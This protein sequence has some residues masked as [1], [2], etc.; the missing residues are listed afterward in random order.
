MKAGRAFLCPSFLSTT[1]TATAAS[2]KL[3][4]TRLA[5]EV[6]PWLEVVEAVVEV[7]F[8]CSQQGRDRQ[9]LSKP[10]RSSQ[11]GQQPERRSNLALQLAHVSFG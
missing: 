10:V 8:F 4:A 1:E 5:E 6:E 3:D 2:T 11:E 9:R 7:S